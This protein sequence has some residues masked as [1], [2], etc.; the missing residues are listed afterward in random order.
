MLHGFQAILAG[1]R[2]YPI[3]DDHKDLVETYRENQ[4]FRVELFLGVRKFQDGLQVE[5][6]TASLTPLMDWSSRKNF[7][8]TFLLVQL[9][10]LESQWERFYETNRPKQYP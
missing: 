7:I 5:S 2:L 6:T 8:Q 3:G 1:T 9:N 10:V 4:W